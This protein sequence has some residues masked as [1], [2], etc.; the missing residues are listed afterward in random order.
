MLGM[1]PSAALVLLLVG[2][3]PLAAGVAA[4]SATLRNVSILLFPAWH[5]SG[6]P[7]TRGMAAMG[8]QLLFGTALA[9]A[10]LFGLVPG[11]IL[12]GVAPLAQ[13]LSGLPWSAMAFPL[14]GALAAAPVFVE[15]LLLLRAGGRLWE[16]LD[17]SQE[18]LESGR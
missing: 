11:A 15:T 13:W 1:P 7:V 4:L 2:A 18:I 16:R 8:Q 3:L 9:I 12:V 10:M 6:A 17:P 5:G 14:W